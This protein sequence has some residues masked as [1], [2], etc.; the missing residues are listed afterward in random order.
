LMRAI[1]NAS[2]DRDFVDTREYWCGG[3][4]QPR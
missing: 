3:D 4:P 1:A 2:T